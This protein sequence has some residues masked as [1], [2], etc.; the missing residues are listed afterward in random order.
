MTNLVE[1]IKSDR[2][3]H[4]LHD[5]PKD[6]VGAAL[7]VCLIHESLGRLQCCLCTRVLLGGG[8]KRKLLI[9]KA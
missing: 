3:D 7:G 4:V 8:Q 6:G 9:Q 1:D 2:V 5:H